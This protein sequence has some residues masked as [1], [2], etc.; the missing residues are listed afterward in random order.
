MQAS[1]I[2]PTYNRAQVLPDC[3][4]ALSKL[5][6]D[7]SAFEIVILDN[8][9]TDR[10]KEV[11]SRFAQQHSALSVRYVLEN[12]QGVSHARNRGI[13]EAKNE[14]VCFLDDDSPPDSEWLS[15][16]IEPFN[17][18]TVGCVGGPSIPD[19]QG[20]SMPPWLRGDLQCLLSGYC[21]SYA[22]PTRVTCWEQFPL[23]C[24]MAIRRRIF[25]DIGC[26]R[27]DLDRSGNE[28]LAAAD[29][30][31]ANRIHNAGWKVLYLP[32][33]RVRH[34]VAP[35]RLTKAYL[36][37]IGRGLAVSHIILTSDP[38]LSKILRWFGSDAWYAVR[39]GACFITA[40]LSRKPLWYDD[41]MR[42]WIV[43]IRLPLRF[44]AI[45][46]RRYTAHFGPA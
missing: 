43:A 29:T 37:R 3:L 2:I 16:I 14:I 12:R 45:A 6:T 30:E 31:M 24:N 8:N 44:R 35:E 5:K 46:Y 33:A 27:T 13:A 26:F 32:G 28:V 17:D 9:S 38:K 25:S 15:S 42:L 36:Y 11:C 34:L 39:L 20:R 1:I 4:Q 40:I 23:S 22:E 41:Y 7:P 18:P 10:T 19:F 21:L